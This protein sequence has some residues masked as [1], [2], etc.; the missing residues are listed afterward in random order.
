MLSDVSVLVGG[1]TPPRANGDFFGSDIDWVTPSDLAPIGE[2]R[3]LGPVA[4]R[5]SHQ[6][7]ANSSA[8]E[9]PP[10]T[11]LFSSRA[12]IGKIAIAD[13]VCCTNQGFVNFIPRQDW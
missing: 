13:R 8:K 4:E 3:I 11:V 10:G 5:L 9:L 7:L 2:V 6:G 12:S 1:G